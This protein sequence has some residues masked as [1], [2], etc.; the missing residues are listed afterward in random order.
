MDTLARESMALM[1]FALSDN[2]IEDTIEVLV[3]G[4]PSADWVYDSALNAVVF[5]V[6][7]TDGALIDISYAIWA[8]CD[9]NTDTGE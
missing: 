4:G 3:D 6:A 9:E 5:T 1:S 8:N 7:P 2:P